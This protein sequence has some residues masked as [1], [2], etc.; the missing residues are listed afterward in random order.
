[1]N[2]YVKSHCKKNLENYLVLV[3]LEGEEGN[4]QASVLI[5]IWDALQDKMNIYLPF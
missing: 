2:S 3:R 1:M 5:E 4:Q